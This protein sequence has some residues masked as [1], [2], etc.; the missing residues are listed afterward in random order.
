MRPTFEQIGRLLA[1]QA[2]AGVIST[3]PDT[4]QQA[5]VY[6]ETLERIITGAQNKKNAANLNFTD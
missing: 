3:I 5:T 6:I 1:L 2:E 4:A